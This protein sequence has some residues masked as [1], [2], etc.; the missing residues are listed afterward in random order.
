M[1]RLNLLFLLL[2][3][4]NTM[5]LTQPVSHSQVLV[6]LILTKKWFDIENYYQQH[7]D[8]IDS[9][10]VVLWYLAETGN[11]FNR[12]FEA[13]EAYEQLIDNNPLNMDALPLIAYFGYPVIQLCVDVQE[14]A[15]GE[16]FCRKII[17]ILEKDTTI[18]AHSRLSYI[19]HFTESMEIINRASK[20]YPKLTITK[21]EVDD[22]VETKLISNMS[23]NDILFNAKWNGIELLTNFDTG[24]SAGGYI[25]NR[26]I[27]EKIG[28]K[29][30][31]TDTIMVNE[32]IGRPIRGLMG[33]IDSLE[34]GEFVIKN[35]PE[36]VVMKQ[37]GI[38]DIYTILH[39]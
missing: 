22:K 26:A 35:L 30:N 33:F 16:D 8:S 28:V 6:D 13:I 2:I 5:A 34:L 15:K 36:A 1:K 32:N 20:T 3:L 37:V 14:Y 38:I 25:Y 9:E 4:S 24:T 7:K 31:T 19:Q 12:P 11:A 23:R 10:F 18:D 29:F 27:A 39:K 17:T 21:S